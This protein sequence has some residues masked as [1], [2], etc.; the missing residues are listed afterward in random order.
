LLLGDRCDHDRGH[1]RIDQPR[2]HSH[3]TSDPSG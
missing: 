2:G 3:S 1:S